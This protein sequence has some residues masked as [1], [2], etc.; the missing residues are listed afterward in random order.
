MIEELFER[1]LELGVWIE[2]SIEDLRTIEFG[3][4]VI[5][6]IGMKTDETIFVINES[7][8]SPEMLQRTLSLLAS[9]NPPAVRFFVLQS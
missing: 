5:T 9:Q 7:V 4:K 1:L 3:T 6:T 2:L 8:I